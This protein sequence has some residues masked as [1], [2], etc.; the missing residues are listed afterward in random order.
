MFHNSFITKMTPWSITESSEWMPAV[1]YPALVGSG[2]LTLGI[3]CTGSQ[4]LP[5]RIASS[6]GSWV[7]PFHVTQSDLYILHEGMISEHLSRNEVLVTGKDVPEGETLYGL[8]KNFMP[9]GYL[10]QS[11]TIDNQQIS[12]EGII[13]SGKRWVR[14]WDLKR[15]ILKNSFILDKRVRIETEIFMPYGGETVYLKIN[16]KAVK[17]NG[18]F[19]W[20]LQ[21]KMETRGGIPI[22]DQ[23]DE[24]MTGKLT[25][26]AAINKTSACPPNEPYTVI[27]GA[28]AHGAQVEMSLSGWAIN[29]KGP[30]EVEQTA[31]IRLDFQRLAGTERSDAVTRQLSLENSLAEFSE[32]DYFSARQSHI[33]EYNDFWNKTA[34]IEVESADSLETTRRYMLH[35]SEYLLHCGSDFSCGGSPQFA[36]FHQ[37]GWG[38]SNFHDQ[39]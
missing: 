16:R 3:D 18:N 37:N 6:A 35:L 2:R 26:L 30:L 21:L 19:N 28:T 22:F 15:A 20:C 4:E 24:I 13:E 8:R 29:M 32:N 23:S 39:H 25:L 34:D 33:K 14:E 27:Y 38:A 7:A 11:F 31:F 12:G 1:A 10:A 17:D 9:L 5:D 36:F